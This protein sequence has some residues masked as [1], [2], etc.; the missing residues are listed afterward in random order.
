MSIGGSGPKVYYESEEVG[1]VT[2]KPVEKKIR[3][4]AIKT[5]NCP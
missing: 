3:T 2:A 4:S 5:K 1:A